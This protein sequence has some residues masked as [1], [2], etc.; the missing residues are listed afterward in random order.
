MLFFRE[1]QLIAVFQ[2]KWII[3][4]KKNLNIRNIHKFEIDFYEY[5][6][7]VRWA[8]QNPVYFSQIQ[9]KYSSMCFWQ[10]KDF[11][12]KIRKPL[13][14]KH[15]TENC[16]FSMIEFFPWICKTFSKFL[17]WL[18]LKMSPNRHC[19]NWSEGLL[20]DLIYE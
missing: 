15:L 12:R 1:L 14:F 7:R 19:Q 8:K 6:F 2:M 3:L 9:P 18:I 11:K 20:E 13:Q 5:Y 16:W 10:Y 17:L 4:K